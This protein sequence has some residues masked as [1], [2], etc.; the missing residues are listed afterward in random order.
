VLFHQI[1]LEMQQLRQWICWREVE[2]KEVDKD[3]AEVIRKTKQPLRPIDGRLASVTNPLDWADFATACMSAVNCHGVGFVFTASDPYTG[4]DLDNKAND[5]TIAKQNQE[6]IAYLDTY[7]EASPSGVGFHAITKAVL[8]GKGHRRNSVEI[9]DRE[10]YFTFTGNRVG[11]HDAPQERQ[12]QTAKVYSFVSPPVETPMFKPIGEPQTLSDYDVL[13]RARL[14]SNGDKF[15]R[16]WS[17]DWQTDYGGKSQSEADFAIINIISFYSRNYD[18]TVRLFRQSGLGKREKARRGPYV[19]SMVKRS[20]DRMPPAIPIAHIGPDPWFNARDWEPWQGKP[21]A[22]IL[23]APYVPPVFTAPAEADLPPPMVNIRDLPPI[24]G[25]VGDLMR[26]TYSAAVYPVAEVAIA[27]AL[28][29]ASTLFSRTHR[30]GSNGLA[31]WLL[32]L[33][34]TSTGKSF[35]FDAQNNIRNELL[36]IFD[37]PQGG[38]QY[39]Q[40][41]EFLTNLFMQEFGSA[42]GLAQH[43]LENPSTL[44]QADEFVKDI[45]RMSSPYANGND[46]SLYKG[47]LKLTDAA[48]PGNT[49]IETAYSKRGQQ[50]QQRELRKVHSACLTVF[51]TGT[52]AEFYDNLTAGVLNEG[53]IPRFL[54][55]DYTGYMPEENT[56]P[57]TVSRELLQKVEACINIMLRKRD[58]MTGQK[59]DF[60][61]VE[62]E[63]NADYLLREW[64]FVCRENILAAQKADTPAAGIWSRGTGRAAQIAALIACGVNPNA[65]VVTP[66]HVALARQIVEHSLTHLT[67]KIVRGETDVGDTRLEAEVRSFIDRLLRE[68]GGFVGPRTFNPAILSQGFVQLQPMKTYLTRLASFKRAKMGENRAFDDT[69]M[70]L[71]NVGAMERKDFKTDNGRTIKAVKLLI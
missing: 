53:L 7:T 67:G 50:G 13:E 33:A 23:F 57:A 34:K 29:M 16:L 5:P 11:P 41:T 17:G 31:L 43:M 30:F 9:Y 70:G 59:T 2:L 28:S 69:I 35:G 58:F 21:G 63:P 55:L 15:N 22:V 38:P 42:P 47:L 14:A 32:V 52:P 48:K 39:K 6:I 24:P 62:I 18:Q 1:P 20:F 44:F 12:A 25:L 19:S 36:R 45:K 46:Q 61:N 49:Y 65:P 40:R 3:G 8:L 37:N 71:V 51:A 27:A 60:I 66:E 64:K 10:R 4:I 26:F 56:Q 54:I 68:G